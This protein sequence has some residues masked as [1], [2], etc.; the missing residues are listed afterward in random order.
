MGRAWRV[1]CAGPGWRWSRST[2]PTARNADARARPTLSTRSRPPSS[3]GGPPARPGQDPDGNVEAIRAL[4]VAKRS[5][6]A[7]DQDHQPDPPPRLHRPGGDPP[8]P[9]RTFPQ[10]DAK[11][12][13]GMRPGPAATRSS[14]P[15]RRRCAP[16]AG[17][18]LPSTPNAALDAVASSCERPR[19]LLSVYG[20]G[21]DTAAALLVAAGDNPA[22]CAPRR[23]GPVCAV[24]PHRGVLGQGHPPAAQP[25]G[26]R[27]ANAALWHIVITRM[28]S[29]PRT[30]AYVERRSEEGLP[31]RKSSGSSNATSPARSTTT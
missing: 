10:D 13:A 2:A 24:S 14:S 17:G 15:P 29:D 9:A 30:R 18:P 28:S 3:P 21:I 11:Q 20:V 12:A 16:W 8:V 22:G 27:Q 5:A 6:K 26:D 19:D 7:A 31:R 25:G 23:P 4:V 1:T